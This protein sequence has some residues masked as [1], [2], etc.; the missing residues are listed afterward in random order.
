MKRFFLAARVAAL[1]VGS[2]VG[3]GFATGQEILLFFAGGNVLTLLFSALFMGAS[4]IVFAEAGALLRRGKKLADAL[5]AISSFA[6]Y[7]AMIAAAEELLFSLS[8]LRG[9]GFLLAAGSAALSLKSI[10]KLSLLNVVAVPLIIV[11]VIFV[12]ARG[13]SLSGG[14]FRPLSALAYGAMNMLFS[15]AL[16]AKE[17]EKM[18]R[19][20]R[21]LCGLISSALLFLLL[22]FMSRAV[23]GKE[24]AMP[25]LSAAKEAGRELSAPI[26]LLL[27]VVTTMTSC[28]YLITQEI[29]LLTKDDFLSAALPLLG[30][31]LLSAWGFENVVTYL[32]PAVSALAL[33]HS[34]VIFFLFG[35]K[36]LL[37]MGALPA[38]R[39]G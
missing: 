23:L 32:Y 22:F 11:I 19:K 27:A 31:L 21:I 28:N 35:R 30:G 15:G 7:A 34:L 2:V 8:S 37:S 39:R 38:P 17:G 16:M 36:K 26:A 13:A 20:E 24:G 5:I 29:R 6:V 10:G 9:L 12:G 14:R 33:G 3:A 25:F 1:F 4:V 18:S